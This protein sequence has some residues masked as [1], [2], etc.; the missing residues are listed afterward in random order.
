MAIMNKKG[1]GNL[2][3]RSDEME[4]LEKFKNEFLNIVGHEIRTALIGI[5]GPIDLLKNEL[6]KEKTSALVKILD[7]SISRLERFSLTALRITELK[8][9]KEKIILSEIRLNELIQYSLR[10]VQ[11]LLLTKKIKI[12]ISPIPDD[13]FIMGEMSLLRVCLE[14]IIENA[15]RHSPFLGNVFI[16]TFIV[17][18]ELSC[19]ITD[20]GE[21]FSFLNQTSSFTLFTRGEPYYG[22][23]LGLNLTL[24]KLIM[25]AHS[26]RI[27]VIKMDGGGVLVRL[28]FPLT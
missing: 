2:E 16:Q 19:E 13:Q 7:I 12:N 5:S 3:K 24:S 14:S 17:N 18:K 27:K 10:G 9:R 20:Y 28:V 23:N 4:S 26:G 15:I 22:N 21:G 25:E 8:S 1:N 6:D 11:D